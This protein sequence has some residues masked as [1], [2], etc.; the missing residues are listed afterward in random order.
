MLRDGTYKAA[1]LLTPEDSLMPLYREISQKNERGQ[2]L[3]GYEKVWNPKQD[4]CIYTHMLAD[5][6]NLQHEVYSYI[7]SCHRHHVDF[8]KRNNNPTNIKQLPAKEHL[9][10][11]RAHLQYT[12]HRPDVRKE[13]SS[14][15]E[16]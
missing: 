14:S 8:N 13:S 5:F 3:D 10:L 16:R 9:A 6:Y 1:E 15:Y 4:K 2:G 7:I 12:L 11:H